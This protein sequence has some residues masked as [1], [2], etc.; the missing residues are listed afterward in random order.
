MSGGLPTDVNRRNTHAQRLLEA[1]CRHKRGPHEGW[2]LGQGEITT[3]MRFAVTIVLS[4][5]DKPR[6]QQIAYVFSGSGLRSKW[7]A[8][9]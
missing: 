2:L 8:I 7:L 9:D 4:Y 3:L 5:P 1:A 6:Q